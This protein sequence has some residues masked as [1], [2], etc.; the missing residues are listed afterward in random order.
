VDNFLRNGPLNMDSRKILFLRELQNK[1]KNYC[2]TCHENKTLEYL[3]MDEKNNM[4]TV[5][6]ACGDDLRGT[7]SAA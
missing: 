2:D 3:A 7:M 5:C 4:F 1:V 6:K